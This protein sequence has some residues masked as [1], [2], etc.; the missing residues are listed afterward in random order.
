MDSNSNNSSIQSQIFSRL[1][2]D[3]AALILQPIQAREIIAGRPLDPSASPAPAEQAHI[4][5]RLR[6]QGLRLIKTGGRWVVPLAEI[7]RWMA[8][9]GAGAQTEPSKRPGSGRWGKP[10]RPSNAAR[11]IR[12]AAT[13]AAQEVRHG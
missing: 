7:A 8:S 13:A 12:A 1:L 5:H 10:G 4:A 3:G 9:G 2:A 11:A 6:R